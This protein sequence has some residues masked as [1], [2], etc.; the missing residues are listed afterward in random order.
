MLLGRSSLLSAV[1]YSLE[2]SKKQYGRSRWKSSRSIKVYP[3]VI[4]GSQLC[5]STTNLRIP[6]SL[7]TRMASSTKDDAKSTDETFV[8][9][10][11]NRLALE[12]SPYLLQ[13]ARNP[14]QWYP[15]GDEALE[16]A[17][18]EDKVIF[19]S[20]GYSTC[21][22][23]HVMEKESFENPQIAEIM[24]KNFVN[25]KVD[26]E[27][28][29]DI[30]RI[31]MAFVQAIS[32]HGGWPMSVFLAPNLSPIIGGT[33]FPPEDR[34]GYPGF[35]TV[36]LGISKEWRE[37]KSE[38][39]LLG[40]SIIQRLKK[41]SENKGGL[42]QDRYVPSE[43]CAMIC[44]HQLK[45]SYEP[46]FGGF[47]DAPKFPQPVNFN[48][49]F[50]M[51]ARDPSTDLAR[52]CLEMC[53]HTL[54][55]MALGGIHDHIGQGFS[56]YSVDEEW[57][58]PHFEKMLY[59]QGQ[60]LQSYTDAFLTTK[61]PLFAEIIDDIATYVSRDLRHKEGGFYSAEDAD[62]YPTKTSG[63]KKEGAFYVWTFDEINAL[64]AKE[65]ADK[66]GLK[67]SD[68]FCFHFTVKPKGNVPPRRDPHGELSKQNVLIV[69]GSVEDT[70]RH[71][72]ITV[73]KTQILLKEASRILF[74]AREKRPRP[75]LDDKILTAWNGLMIS[76]LARAGS[77]TGNKRYVDLA[78]DAAKFIERY[79]YDKSERSLLR[80]CYRSDNDAI[81]LTS[82]PIRGY[83]ADYAFVVKGLLDLY[84]ANLD[85]HW[86]EFAEILQ[87]IQ[88]ELFWD[89]TNG[90]YYS[91]TKD[92]PTIILRLRDDH[93]GAEPCSNSIACGNLLR[94]TAYL[95]RVEFK[96]KAERLLSS[97]KEPLSKVPSS[98]A[99][100]VRAL[101][102]YHDSSTEIYVIG[103][104]GAENTN[105]LL[106]VVRERLIPGQVLM[107]ADQDQSD[108][109]LLRKNKIFA[110]MKQDK[111]VPR[112]YV[113]RY[114]TC[115]LAVTTPAELA[116]LLS[117]ER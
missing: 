13:H 66:K 45:N 86:L 64:L 4:A 117:T 100:M 102:Q 68:V 55:K 17:K 81:V 73:E 93:D 27:E 90:G 33:Y 69:Y 71:F 41:A 83:H 111:N 60:L 78:T 46:N 112:A 42:I 51:Y 98:V 28:R 76:G 89:A 48:L 114:R 82:V 14:V 20:V 43:E 7:S 23:C 11:E 108:N 16:K 105:E 77:A 92:D 44:V 29:P 62:S 49:L 30:D 91:T 25:I 2:L 54:K 85:P 115:S 80:S 79:L 107:F 63:E 87:D 94:L 34:H 35:K 38:L 50:Y 12:K 32:G 3:S 67:L 56:R 53:V 39:M 21:H 103:D 113:C 31:Y 47:S 75:H 106:R 109:I 88:D 58:V 99:E 37:N 110:K 96:D 72:G 52:E 24:N 95:E 15:W 9:K 97:F 18:A 1:R 74:E 104:S 59:D 65:V 10:G 26:R 40:G 61:D 57:H 22:W 19:L 84:E 5:R 116:D 70:A 36:L 6:L 8:N 101:L